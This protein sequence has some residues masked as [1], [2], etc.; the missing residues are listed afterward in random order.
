MEEPRITKTMFEKNK[1]ERT[2][3]TGFQNLLQC[4]DNQ[5]SIA[6]V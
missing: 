6:L 5:N 3:T 4:G 2:Y 1:F